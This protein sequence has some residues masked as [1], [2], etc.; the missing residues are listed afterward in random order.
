MSLHPQDPPSVPEETRRVAWAAFPKGTLCL[1]I[2]D[3]L[4][5]IYQDSQFTA[6]FSP[7]GQP[8]LTPAR[9]ALVTALQFLEGLSDRQAA[10]AGRGRIDWKWLLSSSGVMASGLR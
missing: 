6:L 2:A 3:A 1:E 8:A 7:L 4:G 5:A 9:L 10:D